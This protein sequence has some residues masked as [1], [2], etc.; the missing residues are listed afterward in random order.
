ML[1]EDYITRAP[2]NRTDINLMFLIIGLPLINNYNI[3]NWVVSV[4][5][6]ANLYFPRVTGLE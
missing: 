5:T 6:P 1:I 2:S 3:V 4:G